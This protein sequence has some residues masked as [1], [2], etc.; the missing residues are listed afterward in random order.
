V[1][2]KL[3]RE[4]NVQEPKAKQNDLGG[5]MFVRWKSNPYKYKTRCLILSF[6][7]GYDAKAGWCVEWT[8][9]LWTA[10]SSA[11]EGLSSRASWIIKV[12]CSNSGVAS[13]SFQPLLLFH[14]VCYICSIENGFFALID[15]T[16]A[17][18]V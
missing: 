18:L 3:E 12:I 4:L 8:A 14:G 16:V 7:V 5:H 15:F 9:S 11:S 6:I 2:L 1:A 17:N 13:P 10:C